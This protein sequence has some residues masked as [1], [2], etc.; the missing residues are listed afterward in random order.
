MG[1]AAKMEESHDVYTRVTNKIIDDLEHGH[2]TWH[3]PWQA[4][5][6]AGPVS[7]PLRSTGECYQGINVLMLWATAMG[8]GYDAPIWMTFKQATD[9]CAHVRKGE[10]GALVVYAG[11]ITKHETDKDG[12][13]VEEEIPFLKGYTVFNVEQIEGLPEHYYAR[14]EPKHQ[15]PLERMDS[16]ERFFAGTGANILHCGTRA[17]YRESTDAIYMPDLQAFESKE[18]YYASASHELT[19]WTGHPSRLDRKFEQKRFGDAGY[20]MEELVAEIGAAF[21]CADLEITHESSPDH[22]AYI[23]SWL[24]VLRNDKKAVFTAASHA[25]RAADYLHRLQ[26]T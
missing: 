17:C 22:A 13:D 8:K 15:T 25:Q 23:A 14:A 9:L 10:K 21:L 2:L 5:H 7:R 11:R 24:Q 1:K 18:S 20:A 4:G 12:N 3:Q 19:H 26:P 16:A 6:A